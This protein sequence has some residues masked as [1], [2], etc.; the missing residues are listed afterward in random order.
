MP[1][2]P[3]IKTYRGG[4]YNNKKVSG[5]DD[6]VYTAEDI[7]K[8]Y[9][10]VF[11]DGV[12]PIADG[13]A[14][15]TL[16]VSAT[17]GMGIAVGVGNAKLGGAWFENTAA[18]N[19]TLDTAG[20]ADRYDAVIIRND[21]NDEVREPTIYIQSLDHIPTVNDLTREGD[22]YE[23]CVAYVRVPAF[24][25]SITSGNIVDTREDGSLCNV[26]SG[27][28][29]MVVR[30]YRNTYFSETAGQKVIPIGIPQFNSSRDK[31]TVVVE[32]RVFAVGANYTINNN[33]QITLAI[34][35]PVVGTR[36]DFEVA[37]NVNAAGAETV[38]QEVAE[39]REEM[40][41][42]NKTLER[43]YY[44]NG[45][46]DNEI[47]SEIVALYL[48]GGF[49]ASARFVIHGHLGIVAPVSGAG[50]SANPY[51]Y[52]NFSATGTRRVVVDFSDC[53]AIAPTVND[54]AYSVIFS[55]ANFTIVGANVIAE[56]RATE[57]V[58]RASNALSG[59]VKFDNCFFKITGYRDSM[60]AAHGIFNN[61]Y[62]E[63]TNTINNSYCFLP[64][65]YGVMKINGGEYRA[66]TGASS[67]QSAIVGQS[68]A[69]AVSILYGVS[70]PTVAKTGFYQT[71]SLL[72]WTGGGIMNCTDLVSALPLIV[73][74][75]ISNIRGTI[76]YSKPNLI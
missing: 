71:N 49:Y 2:Y 10:T 17:S 68:D 52:F 48:S 69:N 41:A 26:M 36:I 76:A 30:T 72:Q 29:A 55:G 9:D 8:P 39:L 28:G 51:V 65:G 61:C 6:R 43:H 33:S 47:I 40:T 19:I 44:C 20:S 73:V 15:E 66:Y 31:L 46:N 62:G 56:N 21:D 24:A 32:G 67:A 12:L 53:S 70:A 63:A 75:G 58:L 7:R 38:V 35:L 16:K 45:V 3:A 5:T 64:S 4:F 57:T 18:Y 60:I 14:G 74:S 42:T 22:I 37:K 50:T 1:I 13:T 59:A 25:T 54:G 23:I 11:T 34:G 27:V